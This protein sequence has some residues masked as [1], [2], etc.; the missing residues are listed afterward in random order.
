[1]L[2]FLPLALALGLAAAAP[3]WHKPAN[4][5]PYLNHLAQ[6]EGKLW[7]GTAADIPGPEQSDVNYM[8]ILNDTKIFGEIT[9]ANYMKVKDTPSFDP[10]QKLTH[11]QWLYTEPEQGVFN[12]TGG[13]V[14]LDIAESQGKRVRCH[15]LCWISELPDWVTNGNW[16]SA[17]LS[18]VLVNHITTIVEHWSDRCYSWDV[19]NEALNSNGTF[20]DSIFYQVIGEEYFFTAFKAA[21]DAV[22]ATGKDIK[23]YYNDYGIESPSNKTTAA[24]SLMKE[25]QA[26]GIRVDGVGFESHFEVG[27]TPSTAD[28]MAAMAEFAALGLDVVQTEIDVRFT[29]LPYNDTG[30]AVQKQNYYDTVA[31][32]MGAANCLAMTVWDF[33]DTYSWVPS[34]FAGQGGADLYGLYTQNYTRKPAYD[35]CAEA[36]TGAPCSG[37]LAAFPTE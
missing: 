27:G 23:L 2:T 4:P 19:V 7:F 31:A 1:M 37:C 30:L 9:P 17:T 28:Q 14:I 15:N 22:A 33:D 18:A 35:G 16:T 12:Y 5:P 20:M 3:G 34:T 36:I 21:S 24:V 6:K 25:L 29:S 11:L 13:D 32:C 10:I 8:T 26:R